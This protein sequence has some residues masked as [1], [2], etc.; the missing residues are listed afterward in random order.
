MPDI[1]QRRTVHGGADSALSIQVCAWKRDG[2]H[3]DRCDAREAGGFGVYVRNPTALHVQDFVPGEGGM[4][5]GADA[6]AN[7]RRFALVLADHLG[8]AVEAPDTMKETDSMQQEI[9]ASAVLTFS[10]DASLSADE[11][12]GA[13]ANFLWRSPEAS[14]RFDFSALRRSAA[15]SNKSFRQ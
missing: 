11:L 15:R 2:D 1:E 7:A 12:R 5:S 10:A 3:V 4:K 9:E 13:V 6:L 8:C 14:G